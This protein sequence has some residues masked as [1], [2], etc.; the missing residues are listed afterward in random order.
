[1]TRRFKILWLVLATATFVALSIGSKP[2]PKITVACDF[3]DPFASNYTLTLWT[4]DEL[5]GDW[6]NRLNAPTTGWR[7]AGDIP[8]A[9]YGSNGWVVPMR[10]VAF[11]HVEAWRWR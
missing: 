8:A 1:M 10:D 2:A 11:Y 5:P 6:E 3:P 9:C 7:P 4:S